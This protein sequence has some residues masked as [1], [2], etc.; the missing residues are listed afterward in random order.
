[1]P[2]ETSSRIVFIDYW[3]SLAI[4]SM[5]LYHF[6][7]DLNFFNVLTIDLSLFPIR[8]IQLFSGLSFIFISGFLL[9]HTVSPTRFP[10]K[11]FIVLF[12]LAL[13]ISFAS[14]VY[15]NE[16][17]IKFG[18]IHFLALSTLLGFFTLTLS[19]NQKLL[20]S[21][22]VLILGFYFSTLS[23][24]LPFLF[25]LNLLTPDFSSLDFYPIFPFFAVFLLGQ[26]FASSPFPISIEKFLNFLPQN[27]L[28]EKIAKNSLL[29]YI[30]H[31][32]LL[33]LAFFIFS[34]TL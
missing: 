23:T 3:K 1:M 29:I 28:I 31:Q 16:S 19:Q 32:P 8:F 4:L 5:I 15:P 7:F 9:S 18:I 11:R 12:L 25:F 13:C 33:I 14:W 6:L 26:Y 30:V 34:K 27:H 20:L 17:Y 21:L 2:A 10:K 22:I 24:P